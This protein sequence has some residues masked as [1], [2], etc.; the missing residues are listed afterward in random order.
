MKLHFGRYSEFGI[1]TETAH[2]STI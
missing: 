2:L 1:A